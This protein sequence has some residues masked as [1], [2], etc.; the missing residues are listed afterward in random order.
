MWAIL[1]DLDC[2]GYLRVRG[3]D[4]HMSE[5]DVCEFLAAVLS[6]Y[7]EA[8][9]F[10]S[11]G[12]R[13]HPFLQAAFDEAIARFVNGDSFEVIFYPEWQPM[14][15]PNE[16]P[17]HE[18]SFI[19][20][21]LLVMSMR[22]GEIRTVRPK[23]I[24]RDIRISRPG[25]LNLNNMKADIEGKRVVDKILRMHRKVVAK[26]VH[27]IDLKTGDR[28]DTDYSRDWYGPD[29]ARRC[30]EEDDLFV[31]VSVRPDLDRLWG[32]KPASF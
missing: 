14:Y 22:G 26:D 9:L 25:N 11:A 21:P 20:R 17:P 7:P 4:C 5:I 8:R 6:A 19:N 12:H 16:F 28:V 24:D 1:S 27:V 29:M 31:G 23:G 13:A 30:R 18:V 32:L 10:Y 3:R 15:G 2:Y